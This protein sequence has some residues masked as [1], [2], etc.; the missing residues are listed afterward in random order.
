MLIIFI[1]IFK[2]LYDKKVSYET[3]YHLYLRY[4]FYYNDNLIEYRSW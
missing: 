2:S 4:I 3:K 1:P